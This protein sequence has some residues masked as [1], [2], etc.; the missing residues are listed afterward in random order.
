MNKALLSIAILAAACTLQAAENPNVL[1]IMADDLGYHDLGFQGSEHIRTPHLDRLAS[2]S[3]R[4]TDGHTAASVCSPSR[5][6]FITGRYQQRFGH[7]A[8]VPPRPHGMDV[9]ERTMGQAF[10]DLGYRTA[11]MGKWHLGDEEKHY[12][13]NRGFDVFYG[14]REGSRSFWY[15]EKKDDKP[16]NMHAAEHNGK[17]VEFEGHFSDWLGQKTIEFIDETKDKPFFIFLSFTAPHAPL[18]S[19]P[20]DMEALGTKDGYAGLV[21]GMDRNIGDVLAALE[22]NDEMDNT[23]IWFLSDNGGTVNQASNAPLGGK[24]GTKLEGGHRV[25]F[26]LYWKD[27][28]PAGKDYDKMISAMDIMPTSLAAAGGSLEQERPLDGVDLMPYITGKKEGIPHQQLYWRKLECAAV[29]DGNW[30]LFRIEGLDLAL[31]NVKDDI[32]EQKNLAKQHPEKVEQLEKMLVAWEQDKV[33]PWWG[34][35]KMWTKDRYDYHKA[36]FETGKPPEKKK[37]K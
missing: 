7:E 17:Q 19:K 16:G 11:I 4:F 2:L 28:V 3:M 21:Y 27:H 23:I 15:N 24:K 20:E 12:P 22:R 1:V 31:Y 35:G 36:W 5:A 26:L 18:Q 25:P 29:R 14:L 34:E 6:G 33:E 32:G 8:N 37:K 30:K 13:T 10:K 9:D